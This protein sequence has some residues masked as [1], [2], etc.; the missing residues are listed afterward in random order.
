ME[1]RDCLL[2]GIVAVAAGLDRTAVF[3][4]M[5]SRPI[6]AAPLTGW[7][8]GEPLLGLQVGALVELLWLGR[9]PV[10]AAI[11]PDDTQVAVGA[12]ALAAGMG[13][14]AFASPLPAAVLATLVA[15]PLGKIG[16]FFERTARH[17]NA[18]LQ[19]D[20]EAALEGGDLKEVEAIH[21]R[22]VAHFALSSLGTYTVIILVGSLLLHALSPVLAGA[23]AEGA[24]WLR[25]VFI[26]AG[27]A[28]LLGTANVSRAL[29][30]FAAS[31]STAFLMLWLL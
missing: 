20:A 2:A 4:F 6:V 18:R 27:T 21:L 1:W 24:D 25:L 15:L 3:Q 7:L 23:A 11:P 10:G 30:L 14:P 16:Q 5:I 29:S 26:L 19:G 8:L 28:A 9:L 13:D 12:T 31:F 17:R 22:G